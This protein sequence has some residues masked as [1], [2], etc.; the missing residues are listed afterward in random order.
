M[1]RKKYTPPKHMTRKTKKNWKKINEI[2]EEI[3]RL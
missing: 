2:R 1:V 3:R